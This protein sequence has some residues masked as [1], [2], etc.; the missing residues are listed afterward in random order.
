MVFLAFAIY[1]LAVRKILP[2]ITLILDQ[3]E[4]KQFSD[5][6][7][8]KYIFTMQILET[9]HYLNYLKVTK[10]QTHVIKNLCLSILDLNINKKPQYWG[11]PN[12][13]FQQQILNVLQLS[14]IIPTNIRIHLKL[15]WLEKLFSIVKISFLS[16]THSLLH[17]YPQWTALIRYVCKKH[18]KET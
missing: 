2:F 10:L 5:S 11:T 8:F 4:N 16:C 15:L 14:D 17:M 6:N 12:I 13:K 9:N 18:T 3:K 1:F 7:Y